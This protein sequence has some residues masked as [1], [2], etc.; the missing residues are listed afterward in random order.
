MV[1]IPTSA[2]TSASVPD[3]DFNA[4]ANALGTDELELR[5]AVRIY[6]Y[7][8]AALMMGSPPLEALHSRP[9]TA[10]PVAA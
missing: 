6:G 10:A 9:R 1:Q 8:K 5:G 4:W 2:A 7:Q 3:I